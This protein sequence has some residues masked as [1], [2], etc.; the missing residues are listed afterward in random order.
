MTSIQAVIAA[1]KDVTADENAM[2]Y[3]GKPQLEVEA[4]KLQTYEFQGRPCVGWHSGIPN[5]LCTFSYSF[6]DTHCAAYVYILEQADRLNCTMRISNCDGA[7]YAVL[8]SIPRSL[9]DREIARCVVDALV[10]GTE[11]MKSHGAIEQVVGPGRGLLA[12]QLGWYSDGG[13]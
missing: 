11:C 2:R 1:V 8:P 7:H 10:A 6:D 12:S 3:G 13:L 4:P 5:N 9:D